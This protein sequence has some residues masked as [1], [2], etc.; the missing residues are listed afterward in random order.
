MQKSSVV[1]NCGLWSTAVA[2]TPCCT[3]LEKH[4]QRILITQHPTTV[5]NVIC[6]SRPPPHNTPWLQHATGMP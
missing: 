2:E 3:C 6:A 5:T 1:E 4:H